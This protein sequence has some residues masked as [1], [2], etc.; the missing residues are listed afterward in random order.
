M[1]NIVSNLSHRLVNEINWDTVS[2]WSKKLRP[3]SHPVGMETMLIALQRDNYYAKREKAEKDLT[4]LLSVSHKDW[5]SIST[6]QRKWIGDIISR[7]ILAKIMVDE[8]IE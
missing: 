1:S 4:F 5:E 3:R 6:K 8:C 7:M 2:E